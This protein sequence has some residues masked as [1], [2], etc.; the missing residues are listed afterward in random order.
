MIASLLLA[1]SVTSAAAATELDVPP[2]MLPRREK[3]TAI[4]KIRL[5]HFLRCT[6]LLAIK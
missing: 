6:Y 4:H 2:L 5:F 1:A 3:K